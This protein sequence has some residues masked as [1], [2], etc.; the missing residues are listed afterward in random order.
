[1]TGRALASVAAIGAAKAGEAI[2]S[3]YRALPGWRTAFAWQ[4]AE[5]LQ[6]VA[7]LLRE[8][9]DAIGQT[10]AVETGK[11]KKEAVAE[12]KLPAVYFDRFA[13]EAGRLEQVVVKEGRA[14]GPQMVLQRAAGVAVT[15]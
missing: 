4:R 10:L 6:R 11:L 2:D 5:V 15:E 13:E 7:V 14:A 3:A 12:I 9:A 8:R 1:M